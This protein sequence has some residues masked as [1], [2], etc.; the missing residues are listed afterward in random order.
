MDPLFICNT[1]EQ[2]MDKC[3]GH[4][5]HIELAKP[6]YYIQ[7]FNTVRKIL[8]IT[9]VECSSLLINKSNQKIINII[10]KLSPKKKFK[11]IQQKRQSGALV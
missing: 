7:F 4:F 6:V 8:Q 5:G 2:R 1:C 3:P 9:C 10:K 11:F